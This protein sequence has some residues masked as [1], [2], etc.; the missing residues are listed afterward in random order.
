M[1]SLSGIVIRRNLPAKRV[2]LPRD[3]N[4]LPIPHSPSA[5]R[6]CCRRLHR[7]AGCGD[8]VRVGG[9]TIAAL[10]CGVAAVALVT[11]NRR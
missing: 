4:W 10:L 5:D 7:R 9:L 11:A 1:L 6:A 2:S 3:R 8:M